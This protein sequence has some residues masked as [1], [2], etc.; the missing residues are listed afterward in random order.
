M[1]PITIEPMTLDLDDVLV[2]ERAS[3]SVPWTRQAFVDAI[4]QNRAARCSTAR[5]L[6][7]RMGGQ[8][9]GYLLLEE[10]KAAPAILP[11]RRGRTGN[12][13]RPRARSNQGRGGMSEVWTDHAEWLAAFAEIARRRA[14]VAA[15]AFG[16]VEP[17]QPS[18]RGRVLRGG[19]SGA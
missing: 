4:N 13:D 16:D 14:P 8:L 7:A 3:F 15:A 19:G 2:I 11:R 6:V 9:A 10:I 5:C 1:T 18:S 12:G 17:H